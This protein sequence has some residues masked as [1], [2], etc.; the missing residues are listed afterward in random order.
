[1]GLTFEEASLDRLWRE[2]SA[3][4]RVAAAARAMWAQVGLCPIC[5]LTF[6]HVVG[7]ASGALATALDKLDNV[8]RETKEEASDE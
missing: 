3:L 5:E 2:L 7:C 1:M 8:S 6:G 4:R